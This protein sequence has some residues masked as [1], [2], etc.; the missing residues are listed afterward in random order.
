MCQIVGISITVIDPAVNLASP[1]P[2]AAAPA[3]V[4]H[5]P[6]THSV[7]HAP[8]LGRVPG[9]DNA[10]VA[11]GFNS[12]GIQCGPGAG[13]ALAELAL[14]GAAHSLAGVELSAADPSRVWPGARDDREW[15]ERRAAEG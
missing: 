15:V 6:D 5:G 7:D 11:T 3:L 14:D 10:F 13:V 1:F 2:D 4:L 12:Q 8:V 9:A